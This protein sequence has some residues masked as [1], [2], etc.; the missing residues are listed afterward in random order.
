MG[1]QFNLPPVVGFPV[2]IKPFNCVMALWHHAVY[3]LMSFLLAICVIII[4]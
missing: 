4:I 2:S 1:Q 3:I